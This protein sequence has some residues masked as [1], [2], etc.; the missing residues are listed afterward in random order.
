MKKLAKTLIG[1]IILLAVFFTGVYAK[2]NWKIFEGKQ[3]IEQTEN[4]INEILGI[5][6]DV[7]KGRKTADEAKKELEEKLIER[8]NEI[9]ELEAKI[10]N[11]KDD[12]KHIEHL[13]KELDTANKEVKK[14][15]ESSDK[16]LEKA[17]KIGGE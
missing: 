14:L 2:D 10:E 3:N 5:L 4:N 7:D 1:T 13:E 15:K 11:S 8:N 6:E 9:A 17:K 12:K 16:A